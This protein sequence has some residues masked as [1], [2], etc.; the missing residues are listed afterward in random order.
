MD[1]WMA[2]WMGTEGRWLGMWMDGWLARWMDG[3]RR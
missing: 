1:G 2:R 3:Y